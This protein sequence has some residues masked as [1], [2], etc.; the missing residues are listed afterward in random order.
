MDW[1][2]WLIIA[3]VVVAL[4]A[5]VGFAWQQAQKERTRRLRGDFGSEYDRAVEETGDRRKAES[6]LEDRRKRVERLRLHD[7]APQE[8]QRLQ[9][10][11]EHAQARFVDEPRE[12]IEDA[13]RLVEQAMHARGY[14][15]GDDFDR[16]YE[17][18][19][20]EYA[21]VLD[22]YRHAR[23]IS[24]RRHNGGKTSTEDLR[25]AMVCYRDLFRELLNSASGPPAMGTRKSA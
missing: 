8:R 25:D 13:E 4:V 24:Y 20:V 1:W 11:W 5:L 2:V 22:N 16:R 10:E 19:S 23:D 14:P 12:A 6:Q 9:N 18:L 17:D 3:L 7:I 15:V 21:N